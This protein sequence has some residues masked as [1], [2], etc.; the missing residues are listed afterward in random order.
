MEMYDRP[1]RPEWKFLAELRCAEPALSAKELGLR[2]GVNAETVRRWSRD[3]MYQRYE[4]FLFE[5]R[6]AEL[7]EEVRASRE[8]VESTFDVHAAEMQERL[9]DI[10]QTTHDQKLEAELARDWLDRAPISKEKQSKG[11][12]AFVITG[13]AMQVLLRRAAEAHLP[14]GIEVTEVGS[15]IEARD[16]ED[17]SRSTSAS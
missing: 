5:K 14:L 12:R 1:V 15:L 11:S 13:E 3:M 6:F 16:G 2:V 8:T 7:P 10:I 4:T 9:L 17:S